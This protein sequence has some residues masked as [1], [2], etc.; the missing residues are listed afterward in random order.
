MLRL[1]T[2]GPKLRLAWQLRLGR[3]RLIQPSGVRHSE[4]EAQA[5]SQAPKLL[6]RGASPREPRLTMETLQKPRGRKEVLPPNCGWRR[7]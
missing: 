7:V 2:A 1:E 5:E 3:D 4:T 6:S